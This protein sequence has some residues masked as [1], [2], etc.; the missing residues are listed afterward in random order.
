ML[1]NVPLHEARPAV[2][3]C[4]HCTRHL[5]EIKDVQWAASKLEFILECSGCG[6]E[7]SKCIE[8]EAQVANYVSTASALLQK[9]EIFRLQS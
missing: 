7:L 2:V 9:L 6:T 3:I 4:P 5:M 1:A 8:G